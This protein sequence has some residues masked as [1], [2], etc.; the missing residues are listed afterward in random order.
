MEKA[1]ARRGQREHS[2]AAGQAYI[3][4]L[5]QAQH[6]MAV[7]QSGGVRVV[8]SMARRGHQAVALHACWSRLNHRQQQ[9][10]AGQQRGKQSQAQGQ[11]A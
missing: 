9:Y 10:Q 11:S 3:Q 2:E 6:T 4:G 1:L 8:R 7:L 5:D